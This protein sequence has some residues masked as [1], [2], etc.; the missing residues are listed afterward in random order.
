MAASSSIY[1]AIADKLSS[2]SPNAY[3]IAT[4]DDPAKISSVHRDRINSYLCMILFLL[5][6][7]IAI[8]AKC[9]L[10]Q[11]ESPKHW[12]YVRT[13]SGISLFWAHNR[14]ISLLIIHIVSVFEDFVKSDS[15][16]IQLYLGLYIIVGMRNVLESSFYELWNQFVRSCNTIYWPMMSNT[17][18]NINYY[19]IKNSRF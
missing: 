14:L 19:L 8:Q 4:P 10:C 11:G 17:V 18:I 3:D 16:V 13:L 5:M 6:S 9:L 2:V 15:K 12:I 1:L 7:D